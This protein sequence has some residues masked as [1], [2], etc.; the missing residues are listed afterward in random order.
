[1]YMGM[2]IQKWL[3][4]NVILHHS[5]KFKKFRLKFNLKV[6]SQFLHFYWI[7]VERIVD[8]WSLTEMS[9]AKLQRLNKRGGYWIILDAFTQINRQYS[10]NIVYLTKFSDNTNALIG[11]EV[12]K[13]H[14]V[15]AVRLLPIEIWFS[16]EKHSH[17]RCHSSSLLIAYN[18]VWMY[19]ILI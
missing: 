12:N 11:I 17:H 16:T 10:T 5:N 3:F 13:T 14:T 7:S 15:A 8:W 6:V 4:V 19:W 2:C 9:Y 1:M 18:F